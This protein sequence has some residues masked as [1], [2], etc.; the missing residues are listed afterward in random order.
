MFRIK[1][2]KTH[3]NKTSKQMAADLNVSSFTIESWLAGVR[4]P[5]PSNIK[6]IEN[7]YNLNPGWLTGKTDHMYPNAV[8]DRKRKQVKDIMTCQS[9]FAIDTVTKL[10]EAS[11]S[12]WEVLEKILK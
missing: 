8:A 7:V 5:R 12:E 6:L 3:L 10:A 2:L 9:A 4:Q 11:D 1:E